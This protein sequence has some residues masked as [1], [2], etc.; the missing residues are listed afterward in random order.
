[1]IDDPERQ[2][3]QPGDGME[4]AWLLISNAWNGNWQDAPD[5]W[6]EAAERWRDEFYLPSLREKARA[7]R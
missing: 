2:G 7:P 6:R 1:M 3:W 5:D 4:F